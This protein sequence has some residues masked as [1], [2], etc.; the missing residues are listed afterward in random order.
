MSD[1][2]N[3]DGDPSDH[4]AII[5]MTG[6]FPGAS[7]IDEF[8]QNLRNGVES[9]TFF[10]AADL[11][12]SSID[13]ALLNDPRYVGADG[14]ID[15][16][17]MFDAAFFNIPPREAELMD[18]QH[19]LFLEC[20]WE[21]LE[22]AGYDTESY[23]GRIAVYGSANLSTY[24]IRN[25]MSHPDLR[26]RATSFQT[27]ITNDKDFIATRVS[28]KM[29]MAGPSMSVAT[30]CSSSF[31]A[32]H[33][34]CQALLNYQCDMAIGGAVSLQIS[35]NEA[36]FYQEGGIGDPDGHC[37]A[38]DAKASG[39]VSG[40]GVGLIAVKRLEDALADGDYI[41]AVIRGTAVNNDGAIKYSYTAPSAEGQAK[42]IAE[43]IGLATVD[44]ET[45]T[46]VETH[47]TGTRL[48][49]PIEV[50]A[51]TR[52]FQN[53]GATKKQ[54][55]AIG[56]VKTNIGHLVN[57]GGV[58]SLIKS[59]L[60]MQHGEI[61]ASLNFDEPNPEIDFINSPFFVNDKLKP[62]ETNGLPRRAGVS[63]F[64]IGGTNVH[65]VIEEAPKI[66]SSGPSRPWQLLTLSAKSSTALEKQTKN[67]ASY[68]ESHPDV[69]LADVAFT[70]QVGRRGFEHRCILLCRDVQN[71]VD[72]LRAKTA[73]RMQIQFQE[74]KNRPVIF[75]FPALGDIP[76]N[77]AQALYKNEPVFQ[78]AIDDC[79]A[80]LHIDL[81]QVF[82]ATGENIQVKQLLAQSIEEKSL[83][84]FAF[85]YALAKLWEAWGIV[86]QALIGDGV[87]QYVAGCLANVFSLNDALAL[88][89]QDG[90]H[91]TLRDLNP[92]NIPFISTRTG[93]WATESEAT[94]IAYWQTPVEQ[95]KA[96]SH[97][98]KL[99]LQE[100]EQV[101][102]EVGPG[103]ALCTYILEHPEKL[104]PQIVL[105]SL[106]E[107]QDSYAETQALLTTLGNLWLAG[108]QVNWY[109]VYAHEYRHR[110][111]LPTYPFERERYWIDPYQPTTQTLSTAVFPGTMTKKQNIADWFYMPGW[112][113][114]P[115]PPPIEEIAD[116]DTWLLLVDEYGIGSALAD[117][118][119]QLGQNV[120]TVVA[121][122]AFSRGENNTYTLALNQLADYHTL[123]EELV[124]LG[125]QPC[126][127]VH[128]G[129]ITKEENQTN[130]NHFEEAQCKGFY[131][132]LYTAQI[133]AQSP[134]TETIQLWVVSNHTQ[135]VESSDLLYAEKATI[136]GVSKV[137]PQENAQVTCRYIDVSLPRTSGEID[138]LSRQLLAEIE[139]N[140]ADPVVVYR[141]HRR[142]IQT[143]D[144][145]PLPVADASANY[146]R[147]NGTYLISSG[148]SDISLALA[149][150][151]AQTVAARLIIIEGEHFPERD[152]WKT[153]LEQ[154]S[155]Q[156]K[157]G[158]KIKNILAL[159]EIGAEVCIL[160]VDLTDI[161]QTQDALTLATTKFGNLHGVIHAV[162]DV[163]D[164]TFK[165][166]QDTQ[167]GEGI[168]SFAPRM[169]ALF[170]L[171]EVLSDQNID[172]CLLVS[173]LSSIL[174]GVGQ[175]AYA[176]AN[177]FM[178][179]FANERGAP[180]LS[181]NWDAWQFEADQQRIA[182]LTPHL[183][184]F[185]ISST[186]G[187]EVF[188]R[189]LASYTGEQIVVSTGDLHARIQQWI[190]ADLSLDKH[191]SKQKLKRHPRPHL[192][193][194]Y[195]P[196]QT[197]LEKTLIDVWQDALGIEK[198]GIDDNFFDLGGDSLIAVRTITLLEKTL[199]KKVS[200]A[201][202][203][204]T[205]SIRSLAEL[206]GQD[207]EELA[208]H[209]TAQ[210][211]ERREVLSRRNVYLRQRRRN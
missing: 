51:L 161:V 8:W 54:Y 21:L 170:V 6:R 9:I 101:L 96:F 110:L 131:S 149:K 47:G 202:M 157:N 139:A 29:N 197:D 30:L 66:A 44:P 92:P 73:A 36:F 102:L 175:A 199:Q 90:N 125:K 180:W 5:G 162:G 156:D 83:A 118:L 189:I 28:Y 204:Q 104:A 3:Y 186:E 174:G 129:S 169:H 87:G 211:D 22:Q 24:L 140:S 25:I 210:L 94:S 53:M 1:L 172:F 60:A 132:L 146:L 205:P 106:P 195:V 2:I 166:I 82:A 14:L 164:S 49:D 103:Q 57:A 13:A 42:V 93:I 142:W 150:H 67:L 59:V 35:R 178:D 39:T 171:D 95:P 64:G 127:I 148:L 85:M 80:A 130:N 105:P 155:T 76:V 158:F 33:L 50:S 191:V 38:F 71:A 185:A 75:M 68:L 61:P 10:T 99:L 193:T 190:G 111:P 126:R 100:S 116:D 152:Q 123:F 78:M 168:W 119:H 81:H 91:V 26:D 4:I 88:V 20:A 62:W 65:M 209:R 184:R 31:V 159:E 138:S 163:G 194:P 63:S 198:I 165:T 183:A 52:A 141:S 137:I 144:P 58:A 16:M 160:R 12:N 182:A 208:Q 107:Q 179:A 109:G 113:T 188:D 147:E 154:E 124:T 37:R 34:A 115:I 97:G 151:L 176:A 56:S 108:V 173:S 114:S 7:N 19:R 120:I 15:D 177:L 84:L 69:K 135:K 192:S 187:C 74:T 72:G 86:P 167:P 200:A 70:L 203:Y 46:Y 201:N 145:V 48:G 18:P 40:S 77:T 27:L 11:A 17:D 98:I 79:N 32:V 153:W 55:C 206:L 117:R 43:A 134:V 122:E 128:L 23:D 112:K 133:L 121:G 136:L 207:E 41:H 45:I 181:V 196:P 143:F 89:V